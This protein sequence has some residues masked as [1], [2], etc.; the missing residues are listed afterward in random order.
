MNDAL[1]S[2]ASRILAAKSIA[3]AKQLELNA[4]LHVDLPGYVEDARAAFLSAQEAWVD[5][6]IEYWRF[7]RDNP[8]E[9]KEDA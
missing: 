7:A 9:T 4:A 8:P 1:K 3:D 2:Y 6:Y 5:R